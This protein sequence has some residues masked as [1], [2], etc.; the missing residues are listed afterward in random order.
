M[1]EYCIL[2]TDDGN[3][4]VY[5]RKEEVL[6]RFSTDKGRKW[7]FFLAC[8]AFPTEFHFCDETQRQLL[9]IKCEHRYPYARFTMLENGRK[10]G[11]ICQKSLLLNRYDIL[12]DGIRWRF[13]MPLYT[14]RFRGTSD[15]SEKFYVRLYRHAEW[16]VAI[17]PSNDS[18]YLI[19]SLAFIHRE[20]MQFGGFSRQVERY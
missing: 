5:S 12:L 19:A 6:Y 1:T 11:A 13:H 20:W 8:F 18:V 7:G 3:G 10:I 16:Y 9:T 17:P 2:C 15:A 14:V 4:E